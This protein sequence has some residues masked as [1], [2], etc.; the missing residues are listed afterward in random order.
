MPINNPGGGSGGAGS[1]ILPNVYGSVAANGDLNIEGTSHATKTTSFV[2][3]QANGGQTSI[4]TTL[5][6]VPTNLTGG[7][8]VVVLN[9]TVGGWKGI[10]VG[11]LGDFG[12]AAYSYP[13]EMGLLRA[14]WSQLLTRNFYFDGTN[15]NPLPGAKTSDYGNSS[16]LLELGAEGISLN[17]FPPNADNT[18]S[19]LMAFS[20]RCQDR[21]TGVNG[22]TAGGR[23]VQMHAPMFARY[24]S[25]NQLNNTYQGDGS[26]MQWFQTDGTASAMGLFEASGAFHTGN[27]F[28]YRKSRGTPETPTAAITDD[29]PM[30]FYS[31]G[32]DGTT[33]QDTAGIYTNI[34]SV[35]A[36]AVPQDI[37]FLTSATNSAGLTTRMIVKSTGLVVI[38][39]TSGA[40]SALLDVT[41]TTKGF[42][43]PRMTKAQRNAI[44]PADGLVVYQTDN[45]PGL[46]VYENGA[47]VKYTATADP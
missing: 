13:I 39:A 22:L 16:S 14:G 28:N 10:V 41:S 15:W 2:A 38:G 7:R 32:H 11:D 19:A 29:N 25:T 30:M 20:V 17:I 21:R 42:L 12:D 26:P 18:T 3:I 37:H 43:P 27:F 24:Y 31:S 8:G 1:G 4:G 23:W 44:T 34:T 5:S 46:R 35:G 6:A 36:G 9:P 40:A 45:T 47:W 33:W